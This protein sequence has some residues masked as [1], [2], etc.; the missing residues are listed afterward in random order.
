MTLQVN[1]RYAIVCGNGYNMRV[2]KMMLPEIQPEKIPSRI[3][4]RIYDQRVH[5]LLGFIIYIDADQQY[6]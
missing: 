3:K 6:V 4:L 1:K 5:D 2:I